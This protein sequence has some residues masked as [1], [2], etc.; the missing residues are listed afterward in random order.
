MKFGRKIKIS[1][2]KMQS[3]LCLESE[4]KLVLLLLIS[5]KVDHA[6]TSEDNVEP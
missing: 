4:I 6:D 5:Q 2:P 1:I 3:M